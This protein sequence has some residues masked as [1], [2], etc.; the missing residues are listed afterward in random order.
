VS[1]QTTPGATFTLNTPMKLTLSRVG[2]TVNYSGGPASGTLST[3]TI[4]TSLLTNGTTVYGDG[5]VF[6]AVSFNNVDA[7]IT[8]LVVKDATGAVV[9]DSAT[10]LLVQYIPA[11]LG[12]SSASLSVVKD[13][14][15][16]ITATATAAG[17]S[18]ATVSAVATD[19]AIVDV[20][21]AN[22]AAN[23]TIT[24]KGLKSGVTTVTVTNLSDNNSYTKTKTITV[25][26]NEFEAVDNYGTLAT[27]PTIGAT[28]AYTDGELAL[29]FDAPPTLN[30]G[31]TIKIHKLS[32]GT[33]VDSIAFSGETLTFGSTTVNVGAQLVR[34]QG[35]VLYVTPHLGKLSYGTGYYVAIPTIAITGK[36]NTVAF[37]GLSN[38][39]TV[40]TWKFTTRAA[41]ALDLT[42]ISVD[43][44]QASTANF[45]TVQGALSAIA[46]AGTVSTL[47]TS[48]TVKVAPGTYNELLRYAPVATTGTAVQTVNIIGPAGNA[49]GDNC[50]VQWANGNTMNGTTQSR[51]SFYF[52]GGN[53]VLQ[54]ITLKN[55]GVRTAVSQAETLYFA[56][57]GNST[58]AA[59]NS[60]FISKQD[61]LQT[62]GR[63]WFYKCY[64]EGNVDYI[65]GSA[66]AALFED[67]DLHTVND[68]ASPTI[69][70]YALVVSRTTS[71]GTIGAAGNGTVG[72]G[73][74]I[75]KSRVK[76]D[77]YATQYFGRD[78]G[79]G[80]FYDQV[81][82]IDVA[83]TS[84]N[85][86]PVSASIGAG[87]WKLDNP[88]IKIDDPP[89]YVGWKSVNCTWQGTA[90]GT[91]TTG[92]SGTIASQASEYDTRDHILNRVVTVTAGVPNGFQAVDTAT[93]ATTPWDLSAF[94]Q[95]WS[96]P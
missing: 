63:N 44:S 42:N 12:L 19:P 85:P 89:Q 27:Y 76:V 39:N 43:G 74:V 78:A 11:V 28:D 64:I 90:V 60:S 16:N 88:Q 80:A 26:V 91:P 41:P 55:T 38:L 56:S 7:K 54:N 50:I 96:A 52:T 23:S 82:L 71:T 15:V 45:R 36:I 22:G 8:K 86:T 61:T 21:V 75:W 32:D 47:P 17:G 77:D 4:A 5:P 31:G 84:T 37:N 66:S 20:S 35:N 25:A 6:P 59:F 94:V 34:V 67:C 49:K 95:A 18:V 40:A 79:A 68:V 51:A 70:P 10:G 93:S 14:S 73:Y 92:T 57:G 2:T 72:K 24:L 83:F 9:Y 46:N 53:L 48:A 58:L 62:S 13:A 33:E 87:L 65:W 69:T 81:A 1:A 3:G 30:T 29:T